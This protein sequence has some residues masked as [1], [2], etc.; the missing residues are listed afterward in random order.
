MKPKASL[1]LLQGSRLARA[2][3]QIFDHNSSLAKALTQ[4]P[5][6]ATPLNNPNYFMV[7][8]AQKGGKLCSSAA[9]QLLPCQS[10]AASQ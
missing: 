9:D 5:T 2:V 10:T 3:G 6:L 4:N 1:R 8:A 7:E